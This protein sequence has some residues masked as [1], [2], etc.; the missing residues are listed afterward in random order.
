M[1]A[2]HQSYSRGELTTITKND[3]LELNLSI[4]IDQGK[5]LRVG[6]PV[7]LLDAQGQPTA[8]GRVSFIA[9]NASVNSQTVLAKA[10]FANSG[11][12]L[13]NRQLVQAKVIWDE[14]PGI[15]IPVTA[16]S[17]L[18]PG[19]LIPVTAVSRLGGETFVFVAQ[20]PEQPKPGM[21]AL[22]AVQKPVKLG[23]IEGNNYQVIEGLKAGEKIVVS[24]ILNLNNGVPII[25]ETEQKSNE[26]RCADYS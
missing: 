15:L 26:Q 17:R 4:P 11:R 14:R 5:K 20:A 7:Q 25:P 6:L 21:P 13:L 23:D 1:F 9:P 2:T 24:G 22:V 3:F 19:I 18:G 8:K 16:V 10:S 12:Q